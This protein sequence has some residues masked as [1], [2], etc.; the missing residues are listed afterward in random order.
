MQKIFR[1]TPPIASYTVHR[2]HMQSGDLIEWQSRSALGWIIRKFTGKGV[3]HTSLLIRPDNF[4]GYR[5]RRFM[6]EALGNGVT[7]NLLSVRLSDYKGRV[8]WLPLKPEYNDLR[9]HAKQAAIIR[10]CEYHP[11]YDYMDLVKQVFLRASLD[12]QK[13]FCSEWCQWVWTQA[14]IIKFQKK[15]VRPG[16]FEQFG[17]TLPKRLIYESL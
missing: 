13:F 7:P 11:G 3:N 17:V 8:Y 4:S 16:E 9:E 6:L 12:V 2:E 15:A 14:E 5:D 10:M 1:V